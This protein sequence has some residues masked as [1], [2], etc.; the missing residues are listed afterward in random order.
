MV[1]HAKSSWKDDVIDHQRPLKSS[2]KRDCELVSSALKQAGI[3]PEKI[4]SSDAIRAQ[5]TALYF[6]EALLV[7]NAD[8]TTN[9][10]LYDFGGQNV[11]RVIKEFDNSLSSIMIVGH[12]HA[13]TSIANMLGNT[14]FDNL[15]TCGFLMIE[16]DTDSWNK[17]KTGVTKRVILPRDL[18]E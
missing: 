4:I 2:G 10:D 17:I 8:F 5:S 15:P 7:S 18:K 1:R 16:F 12:N 13:F 3:V 9:H 6:K 14:Y 11:M